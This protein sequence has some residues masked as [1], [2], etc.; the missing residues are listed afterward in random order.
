MQADPTAI[1]MTDHQP[2]N[3]L[4][5]FQTRDS[6]S[7]INRQCQNQ[8]FSAFNASKSA[9]ECKQQL[10]AHDESAFLFVENFG[11]TKSI[12]IF[13]HVHEVGGT[14]YD[15]STGI[16]F[17]QGVDADLAATLT[18]DLEVLCTK[19]DQAAERV[20]TVT[21]LFATTAVNDIDTLPVGAST[22]FKPRNF[23]P[24]TPFLLS[25]CNET[26]MNHQGSAKELLFA[27]IDAIR[28][29]DTAHQG[30]DDYKDKAKSMSKEILFWCYLVFKDSDSIQATPTTGCRSV[31]VIKAL[32]VI[33]TNCL[34]QN[35][36]EHQAL[37]EPNPIQVAQDQAHLTQTFQRPL[38]MLATSAASNQD[39]LRKLTQ[40]QTQTSEKT[41]KSF[42]KLPPKY[43][44]M[45]QVASS[46]G[47]VTVTEINKEALEFFKSTSVLNASIVLNSLLESEKIECSVSSAMTTALL[48]GSFL[49]INALTPAGLSCSTIT[50]EDLLRTDTL[51][52]GMVLDYS[53][54][55]E[56][57]NAS[58]EK[59]T[60]SHVLYPMDIEGT[61]ERLRALAAL[62]RFFFSERSY[63]S[64]GLLGLVHKCMDNKAVLRTQAYLDPEFIA[65]FL[66]AID[67]RLYQWLRQCCSAKLVEDTTLS[68]MNYSVMFE[69]I[70]LSRFNYRLPPNIRKLQRSPPRQPPTQDRNDR[71]KRTKVFEHDRNPALRKEWKLR[72]TEN[73]DTIFRAK[74]H[75][76]PILTLGCQPCLKYLVKGVCYSDCSLIKSH[77]E[78]N[79][80]DVKKTDEFI[81]SLRG[82]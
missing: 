79:P 21:S 9:E 32:R 8:L 77:C 35:L 49:W 55:F 24:V 48:H 27:L 71:A 5:W 19:P 12:N 72:Q 60:K 7:L 23:I 14:I 80:C 11:T 34:K 70:L 78:L 45:L 73:W 29:F 50:S 20:P 74:S 42:K 64:Q 25:T 33:E 51:H 75:E 28:A 57:S 16:G 39:F 4:D 1:E 30:D 53:T 26:I 69:D 2:T 3:W 41:S 37:V 17:I 82:E 43:Q 52:E 38:E 59:L 6:S 63:P 56:M 66:C 10:I 62:V 31:K 65:K 44:N 58:L 18:P 68:L 22:S 54:K 13:H 76:G 46:T 67:D 40:I 15:H 36:I 61:I 81:K 47:E